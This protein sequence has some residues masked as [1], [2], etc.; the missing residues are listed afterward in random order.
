MHNLP[1]PRKI[2]M[3]NRLGRGGSTTT[4]RQ[5]AGQ[6]QQPGPKYNELKGN[7]IKIEASQE[8][9]Q[10]RKK[11]AGK[12]RLKI[13]SI[14][15]VSLF[16]WSSS[17]PSACSR[18]R[19]VGGVEAEEAS[20]IEKMDR[21]IIT[22]PLTPKLKCPAHRVPISPRA[23]TLGLSESPSHCTSWSVRLVP[24]LCHNP[25]YTHS[26]SALAKVWDQGRRRRG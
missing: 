13:E 25:F 2:I 26:F 6:L 5:S 18:D 19:R 10:I 21:V 15:Q 8:S 14:D 4:R 12:G 3:E 23:D 7:Q 9:T 11:G 17:S 22:D 1:F 24:L 16:G 20:H